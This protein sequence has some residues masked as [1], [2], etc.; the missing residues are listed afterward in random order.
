MQILEKYATA[1]LQVEPGGDQGQPGYSLGNKLIPLRLK[2]G[3]FNNSDWVSLY[4]NLRKAQRKWGV[5]AKFLGKKC[6][7]VNYQ[8]M[9]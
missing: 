5:V 4:R 8:S 7:P 6:V 3:T 9:M 1:V 2:D